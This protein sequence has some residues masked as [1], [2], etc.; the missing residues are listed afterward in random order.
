MEAAPE[1][2]TATALEEAGAARGLASPQWLWLWKESTTSPRRQRK[3]LHL[4]WEASMVEPRGYPQPTPHKNR[5]LHT[6]TQDTEERFT[7]KRGGRRRTRHKG[8]LF[9]RVP[10]SRLF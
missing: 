9:V 4:T 10:I 5:A 1:A 8:G 2:L 6:E 3:G 7:T